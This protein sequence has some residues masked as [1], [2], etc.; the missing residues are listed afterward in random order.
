SASS[1]ATVSDPAVVATGGFQVWGTEGSNVSGTFATFTDPGN[2]FGSISGTVTDNSNPPNGLANV[3]GMVF[4]ASAQ[5]VRDTHTQADGTYRVPSLSQG[6]YS[7]TFSVAG[8]QT[9]GITN[10]SVTASSTT[11]RNVVMQP[12][13]PMDIANTLLTADAPTYT[14]MIDWG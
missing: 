1:T 7:M 12:A 11:V 5:L 13:T 9:V 14:A 3:Q 8:Y 10:V 2:P 4:N 6:N